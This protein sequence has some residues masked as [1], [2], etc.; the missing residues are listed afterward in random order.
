MDPCIL[1]ALAFKDKENDIEVKY[2]LKADMWS[3]GIIVYYLLT[4]NQPF[5]ARDYKELFI[6]IETGEFM[7]P[8]NLKLSKQASYLCLIQTKKNEHTIERAKQREE[9]IQIQSETNQ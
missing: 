1:K 6:K 7:I 8:K 2:N 4:G 3:I 9:A 5:I